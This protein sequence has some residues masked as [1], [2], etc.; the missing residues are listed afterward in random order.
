MA[1]NGRGGR[2]IR[3]GTAV[4]SQPAPNPLAPVW[5]QQAVSGEWVALANS[6]LSSSGAQWSGASPGGSGGVA[7]I[8]TAWGGGFLNTVGCTLGGVFVPGIFYGVH[9]G[10]HSDYAGNEIYVYG[11]LNSDSA[12]WHRI[13]DPTIPAPQNVNRSNGFPVSAHTYDLLI[14]LPTLNKLIRAGNPGQYSD[15]NGNVGRDSYNFAIN[16]SVSNPWSALVNGPGGGGGVGATDGVNAY[17]PTTGKAWVAQ[18]GNSQFLS[19]YDAATETWTDTAKDNPEFA[20]CKA[21]IDPRHNLFALYDAGTVRALNLASTSNAWFTPTVAGS[22]PS[23]QGSI[24][25]DAVGQRFL[26]W[27]DSGR[28]LYTLTVGANPFS[29]GDNWSWGSIVPGTGAT[30]S[31]AASNGTYSRFQYVPSPIRGVILM[32]AT[33]GALYFH[34]LAA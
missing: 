23:A 8:V 7:A 10:G 33:N 3:G 19:S 25:Y 9:G 24:V 2:S 13:I 1:W 31:A 18:H 29:G 21:A 17:N 22:G 15:G 26:V 6:T 28:T 4:V 32:N 5:Y 27:A 11:P 14:Y 12:A 16:P 34:K 20:N 30:P